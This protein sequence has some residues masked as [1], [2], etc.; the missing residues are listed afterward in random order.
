M[1][2][3]VGFYKEMKG[4]EH[5]GPLPSIRDAIEGPPADDEEQILAYLESCSE[6][7]ITQGA[8]LDVI[9]HDELIVGAGS[10]IT[11]GVWVWPIDFVH[12]LRRYHLALP[13][14]FL[15][16]VR[17]NGYQAPEVSVSRREEALDLFL[18][19]RCPETHVGP[20]GGFIT[21][22][23]PVLDNDSCNAV[24]KALTDAGLPVLRPSSGQYAISECSPGERMV[25]IVGADIRDLVDELVLDLD[26]NTVLLK[27]WT[28]ADERPVTAYV[29]KRDDETT[30]FTF[31]LDEFTATDQED[32]VA[33]LARAFDSVHEAG[34]GPLAVFGKP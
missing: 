33:R 4:R 8:E 22:C 34:Y 30:E 27:C 11:D 26:G 28:A 3:L 16:H 18:P 32:I 5:L 17:K 12:Y 2:K 24:L 6:I 13:D 31:S 29:R 14:D 15:A 21:W 10:L 7:F 25:D 9:S 1:T 23:V 19:P 20:T